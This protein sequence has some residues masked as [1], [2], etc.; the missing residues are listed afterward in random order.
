VKGYYVAMQAKFQAGEGTFED[1]GVVYASKCGLV[2][3]TGASKVCHR[4]DNAVLHL[5]VTAITRL[6]E[7]I[8]LMAN[9]RIVLKGIWPT[10]ACLNYPSTR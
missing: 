5:I 1:S 9:E 8:L 4:A 10:G 3:F 6:M 2:S 7:A